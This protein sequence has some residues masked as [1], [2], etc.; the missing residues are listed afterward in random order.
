MLRVENL[1]GL[2]AIGALA[3]NAAP[4]VAKVGANSQ[5]VHAYAGEPFGW[6]L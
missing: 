5:V 6:K 1:A 3:L 4:A 2:A